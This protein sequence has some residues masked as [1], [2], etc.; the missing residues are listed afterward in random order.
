M[1][2]EY[3]AISHCP[4]CRKEYYHY[5]TSTICGNIP[6]NGIFGECATGI[7]PVFQYSFGSVCGEC[8]LKSEELER[9]RLAAIKLATV[10]E[11]I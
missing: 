1:C 5:T 8:L 10:E 9:E 7:V 11:E 2:E 3:H 4:T 6:L